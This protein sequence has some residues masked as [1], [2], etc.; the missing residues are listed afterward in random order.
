MAKR[1]GNKDL[2]LFSTNVT[3]LGTA[4]ASFAGDIAAVDMGNSENAISVMG[5]IGS[6]IGSLD[7]T[8]G[9]WDNIGKWFGGSSENN[10]LSTTKTM[11]QVGTNLNTFAT[12]IFSVKFDGQVD[13]AAGV[14]QSVK[15]FIGG[16]ESTGGV[17]DSLSSWW[18][19]NKFSTLETVAKAMATFG[20]NIR[21]FSDGISNIEG[22]SANFETAKTVFDKF[23]EFG[24]ALAGE[25]GNAIDYWTF[26]EIGEG[27]AD[28]GIY[29]S[30]FATNISGVNVSDLSGAV[31][32][33]NSLI[34]IAS[35]AG[36]ID[37][38][39]VQNLA[40][41]LEKYAKTDFS[42]AGDTL[43][44]DFVVTIVTAIQNGQ[45]QVVA[46]A[47][48]LSTVGSTAI[49]ATYS[50]WNSVGRYL[51]SGLASGI[52]A[53]AG[54]VKRA[55][56][57]AAAGATRAIQITW[58]VHSPSRVGK[59][60]GM[61]FDLGIASGIGEYSRVVNRQATG[62][63]ERAVEAAK[64]ML[65][66]VDSSIFDNLNPNPTI[67]PVL[68]LSNVRSGVNAIDGML[69]S[70]PAL[71]T[72]M[73]RGISVGK[74]TGMLNFDGARIL[75]S[76]SNRDVV[77]ELR[78]LTDKFNT[79][80]EA[81]TNMKVVLDSGELVGATSNKMDRQLGT[82]AMRKGRGN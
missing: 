7:E 65:R 30:T 57:N 20:N 3:Q 8:G 5:L 45:T 60:L 81:V 64:T 24:N 42:T 35:A 82:L 72:E 79:L 52:A 23:K 54:S 62:M 34:S 36:G 73:F 41:I 44:G 71:N 51:G 43:G 32:T 78:T 55:A 68:D 4:L 21:T 48:Q 29:L 76:Q 10:L 14:F 33:I 11:A 67:R 70:D 6:F 61:N 22:A 80:S 66:G 49:K 75:G 40:A 17:G 9:L 28:F 47:K 59:D 15:D 18:N 50:E 58:S 2:S 12:S 74:N 69:A 53:M 37:P 27:L 63:G 25:E 19:G 39:N 1:C 56:V 16:L 38:T 46:S 31:S 26:D 13:T 77:A